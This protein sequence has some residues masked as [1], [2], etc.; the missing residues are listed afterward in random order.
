MQEHGVQMFPSKAR[1]KFL[2]KKTPPFGIFIFFNFGVKCLLKS[3]HFFWVI[4]N[5]E[6]INLESNGNKQA[7]NHENKKL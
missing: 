7:A 5:W 6:I 4:I 3:I 1:E 2:T